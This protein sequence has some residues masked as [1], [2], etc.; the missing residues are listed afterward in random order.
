MEIPQDIADLYRH[1]NKH[2]LAGAAKEK[3]T[4]EL[5][6]ELFLKIGRFAGERMMIW[7]KRQL[8]VERPWT[9][10]PVLEKFKFCNIYRELDRQ[11]IEY[12]RMLAGMRE[13]FDLWLLNMFFCRMICRPETVRKVGLISYDE[14]NNRSVY[15]KLMVLDKPR[16]GNAYVFP[17]STILRGDYPTR[18]KF[19]CFYL[20]T[21]MKRVAAIVKTFRDVSVCEGLE[22]I[23]PV[24]AV[25]LHFL[26][27]EVLIDTA[28][29]Y[30][31]LIDLFARFP[32]GPGSKPT[33]RRLNSRI[34]GEELCQLL[35]GET[36]PDF[37]YLQF[38]GEPVRLSAENWEG[39]GCEFRKYSN[40]AEGK[41]RKR[42]YKKS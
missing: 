31:E 16:F 1:W 17:V 28:Y 18:E 35:P 27:T 22:R 9:N 7:E 29:Q 37:P 34:E 2:V 10:D 8:G 11:T 38:H 20:P 14:K 6:R 23:L 40:L 3:A 41:G 26:W 12:H 33:M 5:D 25:R 30:P 39:V 36:I 21:V 42:F 13:D 4:F 15:E 24:F 19:L 32:I